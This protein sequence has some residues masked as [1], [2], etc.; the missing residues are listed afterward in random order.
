VELAARWEVEAE[1]EVLQ[2][3]AVRVQDLE[4]DNVDGSSSLI[5]SLSMVIEL[6]EGQINT[7]VA[8]KVC[9]GTQSVLFAT[10]LHFPK[11]KYKLEVHGSRCN[12]D[13]I[14]YQADALWTR[15]PAASDSLVSHVLPSITYSPP[16]S[17]REK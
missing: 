16:D 17:A 11:L 1:L 7:A 13:P 5:A 9:W 15:V 10:L 8:H 3:S 14:E 6:L 2:T 4:L 12:A